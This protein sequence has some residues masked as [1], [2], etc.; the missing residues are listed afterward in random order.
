MVIV[1]IVTVYC[2]SFKISEYKKRPQHLYDLG[3]PG[4]GLRQ[5]Q[6]V[7]GLNRSMGF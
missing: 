6:N 4:S 2:Y 3:N 5:A 7:E 1:Y